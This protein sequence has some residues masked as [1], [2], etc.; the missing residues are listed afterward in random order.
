MIS[1]PKQKLSYPM[2]VFNEGNSSDANIHA[3]SNSY[4]KE[5]HLLRVKHYKMD[6]YGRIRSGTLESEEFVVL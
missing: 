3:E 6:Q 2:F 4:E 1:P 5:D